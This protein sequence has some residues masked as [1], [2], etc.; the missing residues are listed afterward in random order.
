MVLRYYPGL[1]FRYPHYH[2]PLFSQPLSLKGP[3]MVEKKERLVL[4]VIGQLEEDLEADPL[5][6][7][8]WAKLIDQVLIKDK[9]EQVRATFDKYLAVFKF[10]A[11]Q[12][13]N[14]INFELNRGDFSRVEKIFARCLPIITDVDVCRTY[15]L[16]VRRVND[17]ITGGEKA[18]STVVLAF[19]F[20]VNRVGFDLESHDLWSDYLNFFKSWTPGTSWEQQQKTDLIRKLYRR[21]LIIPTARIESIWADYTKWENEVSTPNSASKFIADL[22]TAYMEARSW[23]T[24]WHHVTKGAIRRKL[25]PI[26]PAN[27]PS[28]T[29]SEQ[30]ALWFL[31]IDLE[32]KNSLVLK[33]FELQARIEY[34]Y[35][36]AI[37]MLPFVPEIWYRYAQFILEQG[38]DTRQKCIDLI[39]DSIALN[40]GSY[41]LTFQLAELLEQENAFDKAQAAFE[42]LIKTLTESYLKIEANI[43]AVKKQAIERSGKSTKKDV[44]ES[45]ASKG[46][47]DDED[48]EDIPDP[49]IHYNE[50][51][52]LKLLKLTDELQELSNGVT[53]VYIK[54]MSLCKRSQGIKEVRSVFKQRKNF[55]AM[56]YQLYVESALIEFYSDN[57][58]TADKIFDLAMK[59]FGKCGGFLLEYLEYL[60][61]TN[62]IESLKVF[63]EVAVT[64]LSREITSA[65]ELLEV[66]TINILDQRRNLQSLK[67]NEDYLCKLF[68]RYMKFAFRFL[69]LNTVQSLEKRYLQYFPDKDDL[70]VFADRYTI[71]TTD[72]IAKYDLGDASAFK[73]GQED[74]EES[75]PEQ[76]RKRRRTTSG[77]N[78]SPESTS[79]ARRTNGSNGSLPIPPKPPQNQPGHGFVGNTIYGLL[80][81]LPNAGYFGPTH[82]HIFDSGKLVELFANIGDLPGEK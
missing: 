29:I 65:K 2:P 32:K 27:D 61:L 4:D 25:L 54:M 22:S 18:R 19:D 3:A 31:W 36:R 9:E 1:V 16:Y 80:Q 5:N 64:N 17:V 8:Q 47:S 12:W 69:D 51:D 48:E 43:D 57:K 76:S 78:Y 13:S 28:D 10:D 38:D 11:K 56:G 41:L 21:C 75:A 14:Y 6:Q 30:V 26:S 7:P 59:T 72:L 74:A 77:D 20:A 66:A 24:E 62:A 35:K 44:K 68:G 58:K 39:H 63:F 60:I 71:G 34:V 53:L 79:S 82:E 81:V 50:A 15:V 23:N 33:D 49:I 37:S 55:K 70:A 40:P 67:E 46:D 42:N 52:A 45:K 73:A